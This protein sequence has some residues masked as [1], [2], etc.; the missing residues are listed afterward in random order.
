MKKISIKDGNVVFP[1]GITQIHVNTFTEEMRKEIK[2]VVIPS[3]V[4]KIGRL[5]FAWCTN[6]TYIELPNTINV[7]E[8]DAFLFCIS[9][10]SIKIPYSV[11]EI[12][13]SAFNGCSNLSSI[14]VDEGNKK[15]DSREG[16][17][18]INLTK[19]NELIRGF[20]TTIIP[21]SI[22]KI[23]TEAFSGT[24]NFIPVE[25]GETTR[26][27]KNGIT[28]INIP[29]SVTHINDYA[30]AACIDLTNIKIPDSVTYIGYHTFK[31]CEKLQTINFSGT[32][33]RI[34]KNAFDQCDNLRKI[35]VPAEKA[36]HYKKRLPKELHHLIEE[37]SPV[38]Q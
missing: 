13:R 3:T 22:M 18:A 9:L 24:F 36:C 11:T 15:Y 2:H 14:V 26:F 20:K 27:L 4:T 34:C 10:T 35:L 17:N 38:E 1:K 6:L 29:N 28:S 7:I 21:N 31:F 16:C 19:N 8:R 23:G 25:S 30:F 12:S 32:V 5:T 33:E 37:K